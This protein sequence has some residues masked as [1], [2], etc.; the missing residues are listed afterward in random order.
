M[1]KTILFKEKLSEGW[2]LYGKT[3]LGT[4]V[5]EDGKSE[6]VRWLVGWIEKDKDFFPFAYQMRANEV[7]VNQAFPRVKHL[8]KGSSIMNDNRPVVQGC[9]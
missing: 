5:L 7:D 4:D 8:L 6:R 3:G 1:T 9:L 2:G